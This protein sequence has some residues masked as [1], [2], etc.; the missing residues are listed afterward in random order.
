MTC[1]YSYATNEMGKEKDRYIGYLET[2]SGGGD[3][4]GPAIGGLAFAYLGYAG[5]FMLFSAC[6][7][8]GI[9]LSVLLIPSSLNKRVFNTNSD[10]TS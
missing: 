10:I 4:L 3:V 2:S 1:A 8:L 7:Y 5:T 6:I 9:I